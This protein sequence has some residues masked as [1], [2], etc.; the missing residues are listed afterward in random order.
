MT[1]RRFIY[2]RKNLSFRSAVTPNDLQR[3]PAA[4]IRPLISILKSRCLRHVSVRRNVAV[5]EARKYH[6]KLYACCCTTS[7][8]VVSFKLHCS[9]TIDDR[10]DGVIPHQDIWHHADLTAMSSDIR[11]HVMEVT[12]SL[13]GYCRI[14][15]A[16]SWVDGSIVNVVSNA[17]ASNVSTVYRRIKDKEVAFT[18]PTCIAEYNS[19][20]Q[21]VDRHDKLRGRFSLA[22]GHSFQKWHKKIAMARSTSPNVMP[23][24]VMA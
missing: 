14:L 11:S 12:T 21:G 8:Y 20:M 7:W 10:M 16:A 15:V 1:W 22:D 18:A 13:K 2:I 19:A 6:F 3:D 17:D 24:F 4:R 23:T 9:S 5:D